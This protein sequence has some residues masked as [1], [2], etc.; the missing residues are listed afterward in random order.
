MSLCNLYSILHKAKLE[1]RAIGAFNVANLEMIRGVIRA[2]EDL[3]T[4]V[5]LQLTEAWERY[6]PLELMAP[7]MITAAKQASVDVVVHLDHGRNKNVVMKALQLGFSS[8]MLDASQLPLYENIDLVKKVVSMAKEYNASVEG[9]IGIIGGN[10]EGNTEPEIQCTSPADVQEFCQQTNVDA[11]AIAIGN[12][13]GS[14]HVPPQLHYEV[15]EECAKITDTPLV[16]HG[17]SGLLTQD[18]Q[19]AISMGITKINIATASFDSM[20]QQIRNMD[21]LKYGKDGY[22]EL[23]EKMVNGTYESVKKHMRIFNMEEIG[24]DRKG[25][26]EL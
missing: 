19:K 18:F 6:A 1:K 26:N 17:G 3:N 2:A 14:Y 10:E 23:N 16:L 24:T 15:L 21:G 22:F 20:M 9:E 5:I 12:A 25:E 4:P 13:H 11:L 7:V 8:V